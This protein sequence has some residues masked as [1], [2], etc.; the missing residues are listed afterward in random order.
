MLSFNGEGQPAVR[1]SWNTAA[2]FCKWLSK[3][4]GASV[5]L[6]TAEQGEY[7][8]RAGSETPLSYGTLND[9]FSHWSNMGDL[10]FSTGVMQDR[11][12]MM[13]EQLPSGLLG[14]AT[15]LQRRFPRRRCG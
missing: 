7:T 13:P 14:L 8:C 2:A 11:G 5:S 12:R 6:P 3:R 15:S 9:D 1:V 10:S 4:A